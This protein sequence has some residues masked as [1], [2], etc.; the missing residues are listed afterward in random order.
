MSAKKVVIKTCL[1][2]RITFDS[3]EIVLE[4]ENKGWRPNTVRVSRF[5]KSTYWLD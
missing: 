5:E 3:T 2:K 1:G 4:L